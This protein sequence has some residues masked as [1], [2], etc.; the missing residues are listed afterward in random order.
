M[1]FEN[2][3][4]AH[5]LG[6][7]F[8]ISIDF[9]HLFDKLASFEALEI[10][11][12]LFFNI[13]GKNLREKSEIKISKKRTFLLKNYNLSLILENFETLSSV[14]W[15]LPRIPYAATPYKPP[16]GPR[17]HRKIP[18]GATEYSNAS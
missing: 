14:R 12:S 3:K 5:N 10:H 11:P 17:S 13:F 16:G 18:S 9:R 8:K 2:Q 1:T 4:F 7:I 6:K 15:A